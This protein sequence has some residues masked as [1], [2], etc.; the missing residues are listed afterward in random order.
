MFSRYIFLI[1]ANTIV[2]LLERQSSLRPNLWV[3]LLLRHLVHI[4][5][6]TKASVAESVL[7]SHANL[8]ERART[9][10]GIAEGFLEQDWAFR[11]LS[12][13]KPEVALS[14]FPYQSCYQSLAETELHQIC[15]RSPNANS[16]LFLGGGSLPLSAIL[17]A[18]SGYKL[19]VLDHDA[20]AVTLSEQV[21][22][23]L[24]LDHLIDIRLSS[25]EQFNHYNEFDA[26]IVGALVGETIEEKTELISHITKMA[27]QGCPILCRSV[28]GLCA[29]LYLSV[30]CLHNQVTHVP[31]IHGKHINSLVIYQTI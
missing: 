24:G 13:K 30:P 29:F 27:K 10:A 3:N 17:L 4:I 14:Q 20:T 5:L 26:I 21:I 11:I 8:A 31:A 16:V 6:H 1:Q 22:K 23:K 2:W 25:A 7:Q 28:D 15:E 18:K 19:T 9:V 12:H